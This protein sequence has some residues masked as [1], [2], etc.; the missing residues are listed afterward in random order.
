MPEEPSLCNRVRAQRLLRG[1]SQEELAVRTNVSRAGISAIE[2]GR[3]IP[4]AA[5][6]LALAAVFGC[7]VEDI[8]SLAAEEA[9]PPSWAWQPPHDPCRYWHA[10]V[11]GRKL[12]YPVEP[13]VAGSVAHDGLFAHDALSEHGT[14][15][16]ANTLV[17][18]C[19]DP[20][21]GLLADELLRSHGIRLLAIQRPSRTALALLDQGLVHA[22]GIHLG[23]HGQQPRN[24]SVAES[25][26]HRAFALFAR[27]PLAGRP[28]RRADLRL[29]SVESVL[30]AKVRWVGRGPVP[31][32]ASCWTISWP[33]GRRRGASPPVIA[34]W[35]KRS[36]AA[37]PTWACAC[38]WPARRR[39]SISSACAR[40]T[41]TCAIPPATRPIRA[42]K[43][44]SR[45]CARPPDRRMLSDLPGYDASETGE[46]QRVP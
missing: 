43:P 15:D 33:I 6:A 2:T 27:G 38:G 44:S 16:P 46:L 1:W 36:A 12:L 29:G 34:A 35:P 30:R 13:T 21:V 22:A 8:F 7:R 10:T 26:L 9:G 24:V 45:P 20:A 41:T 19:C 32:C 39:A 14:T 28:G 25:Q 23:V 3:L 42:F 4:S 37:G 40:K 18:A 5:T 11:S 31:P 17:I